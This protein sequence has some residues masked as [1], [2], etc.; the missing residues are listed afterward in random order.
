[1]TISSDSTRQRHT[2]TDIELERHFDALGAA[3][4]T[5]LP[6][7]VGR[8]RDWG[9]RLAR[10]YRDGGRLFACGNGGSAAEAQHL[11][12]E[13]TGRF[14]AEREPLSAIALHADTSSVT[15]IANDYGVDEMFARQLRAHGRPGDVLVA[16]S[17]SGT[18]PNVVAAAKAA[19]D[20]GVATW[21]L[22]GPMPNSLAALCDEA[23]AVD[24]PSTAT[25]QE[26]HLV[27]VHSLCTALD[28]ALL[29]RR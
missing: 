28:A 6:T 12:A 23:I 19:A 1:M 13:L 9:E 26:M 17:T 8:V 18:S 27:L 29:E 3:L 14:R 24:A 4:R 10:M 7:S 20:I 11:T 15:A 22:T 25:V 21:A 2:T 16:L 5:T